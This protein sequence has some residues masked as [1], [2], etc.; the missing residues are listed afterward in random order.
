MGGS[1][2]HAIHPLDGTL[3]I[4][5]PPGNQINFHM[6]SDAERGFDGQG[7]QV[8]TTCPDSPPST[9]DWAVYVPWV[10]THGY[11]QAPAGTQTLSG[12]Y[13]DGQPG[14]VTTWTWSL[15][16]GNAPAA[17]SAP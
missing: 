12:S 15:T 17:R 3:E 11:T 14:D 10:D 9:G 4:T 13:S 1:G 16:A 7:H 8:T 6:Y 2:S 5:V